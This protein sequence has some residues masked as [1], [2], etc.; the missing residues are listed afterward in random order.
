MACTLNWESFVQKHARTRNNA[1]TV[2][3]VISTG[4]W[5]CAHRVRAIETIIK[6]APA[7]INSIQ[8]K[9][10][11]CD[12][13][14]QLWPRC[15]RNFRIDICGINLKCIA[16]FNQIADI[17]QELFI[18]R[19]FM[20]GSAAFDVPCIN[21]CLQIIALFQQCRVFRTQFRD[22]LG[23]TR[24]KRAWLHPRTRKRLCFDKMLKFNGDV[25][26]TQFDAFGHDMLPRYKVVCSLYRTE[27]SYQQQDW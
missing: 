11:V 1:G 17:T 16:F 13:H 15:Q 7:C 4:G 21:L 2:A 10:C 23:Q 9:A 14:H 8:G 25:Q 27:V 20:L 6:A 12:R 3:A 5:Q 19:G 22:N 26:T 24:P 18:L